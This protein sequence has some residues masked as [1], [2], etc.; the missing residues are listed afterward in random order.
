[1]TR[2]HPHV[3]MIV[4][5]AQDTSAPVWYRA[6][7]ETQWHRWTSESFPPFNSVSLWFVG[8]KPPT[9]QAP[10]FHL[11]Y[12]GPAPWTVD[13]SFETV[14]YFQDAEGHIESEMWTGEIVDRERRNAGNCWKDEADAQAFHLAKLMALREIRP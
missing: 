3:E 5:A 13:P 14:Y 7:G 11:T 9:V 6:P 2:P 1:M 10:A 4:A 8:P 12:T